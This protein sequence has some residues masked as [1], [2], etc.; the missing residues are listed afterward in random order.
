MIEK[1]IPG[2]A[3]PAT[4]V[5]VPS[6][7]DT[8][9]GRPDLLPGGTGGGQPYTGPGYAFTR[10]QLTSIARKWDALADRFERCERYALVMVEVEG[11][12]A[13]YA[14]IN[15]ADKIRESGVALTETLHR[16]VSY[17]RSMAEKFRSALTSYDGAEG[18][19]TTTVHRSTGSL[20]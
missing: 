1:E 20:G 16:R 14:S 9:P 5:Y 12:G 4:Q 13:E 2:Q 8:H 11:P 7:Q 18:D 3:I 6:S 17:C 10:E 15:N 19:T